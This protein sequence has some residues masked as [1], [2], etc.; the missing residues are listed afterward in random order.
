M[1]ALSEL[2]AL[3]I[4]R[5]PHTDLIGRVWEL[6]HNISAYDAVYIALSEALDITLVTPDGRL[7]RSTGHHARIELF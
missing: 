1:V 5:Y 3:P 2:S 4:T 7:A 6:R